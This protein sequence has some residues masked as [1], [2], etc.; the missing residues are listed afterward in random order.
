MTKRSEILF[1]QADELLSLRERS[2]QNIGASSSAY[3]TVLSLV[4]TALALFLKTEKSTFLNPF[5]QKIIIIA[6]VAVFF[7]G[8]IIRKNIWSSYVNQ[9]FYTRMLNMTRAYITENQ[10]MSDQI[11]LP[12]RGD[13]PEFDKKGF[14]GQMFS[15]NDVVCWIKWTNSVVMGLL[16]FA[17]SMFGFK[18][19][20][21]LIPVKSC[22]VGIS[23]II[24]SLT[25]GVT[26]FFWGLVIY[27]LQ[28]KYDKK[29]EKI[30]AE[31]WS[32]LIR[33]KEKTIG[34]I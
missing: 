10:D 7:F 26:G 2:I 18:K 24:A 28:E 22:W 11:L 31:E 33:D 17:V 3:F 9:I 32:K 30:A 34:M 23:K 4:F 1:K 12:V 27:L 14:I 13:E 8:W 6:G 20:V 16:I 25:F 5:Q 29:V 15:K 19:V 21:D